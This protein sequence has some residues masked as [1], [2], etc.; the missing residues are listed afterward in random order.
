MLSNLLFAF[1]PNTDALSFGCSKLFQILLPLG[2][3]MVIQELPGFRSFVLRLLARLSSSGDTQRAEA[4]F[5][6]LVGFASWKIGCDFGFLIVNRAAAP[7]SIAF[8]FAGLI[9]YAILQYVVYYLLGS[10][11]LVQGRLNPFDERPTPAPTQPRRAWQRFIAKFFHEDGN[12][13]SDDVPLRKVALKPLVDYGSILITWPLYNV[14]LLF[15]QSGELNFAPFVRFNFLSIF[16][17]YV[18]NVFGYILG[19]NFGEWAYRQYRRW[20][21]RIS[22][23]SAA[24]TEA[25][26]VNPWQAFCQRHGLSGHWLVSSVCGVMA[27]VLIEP[28]LAGAI[29]AA[30]DRVQHAWFYAFGHIEGAAVEQ[31]LAAADDTVGPVPAA[32]T[33]IASFPDEWVALQ[34]DGP[35]IA[36]ARDFIEFS[37]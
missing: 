1:W 31:V 26:Q 14:G 3:F 13:T 20:R 11:M 16:A 35:R 8:T 2:V 33:L 15:L 19:Y 24:T 5:N 32:E 21:D 27:V 9:P 18:V 10:K 29:F 6:M 34:L 7:W 28:Y 4:V 37:P 17:F 25:A 22:A 30:S 12:A 23:A 36:D